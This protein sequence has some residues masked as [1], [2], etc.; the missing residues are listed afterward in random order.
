MWEYNFYWFFYI[1]LGK[2]KSNQ[3]MK[4]TIY[5]LVFYHED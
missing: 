1:S 5:D 3:I 2:K 4:K